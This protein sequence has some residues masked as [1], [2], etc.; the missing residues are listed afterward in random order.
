M[1][2]ASKQIICPEKWRI[3]QVDG[4]VSVYVVLIVFYERIYRVIQVNKLLINAFSEYGP[5]IAS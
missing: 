2:H 1:G 5:I 3:F 4:Y